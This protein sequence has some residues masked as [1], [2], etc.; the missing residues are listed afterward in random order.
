MS[1]CPTV[2]FGSQQKSEHPEAVQEA[3]EL[4]SEHGCVLLKSVLGQDYVAELHRAFVDTYRSYFEDREFPDALVVGTKRIQVTV[5]I[6]GPFN[7]PQLYANDCIL[8]V[9]K[10]V[11]GEQLIVGSFGAVVSLAGAPNQHRHRDHPN[12]YETGETE[13]TEPW[14]DIVLPPYALNAIVP[15]VP[16]NPTNGTTHLWPGSHLVP[17]SKGEQLP[18]VDPVVDIGDCLLVDYRTLHAGKA[19]LSAN[20]RPIL[21]NMY[22]RPWFRDSRNYRLQRPIQ[23]S[24]DEYFRIPEEFRALFHGWRR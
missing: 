11:L 23:I 7:S 17:K 10:L 19:N 3:A 15:L 24:R 5:A 21:Y 8:P 18:G 1:N 20:P 13:A 12:I 16:L 4:F 2:D 22:C 14:V 9:L 6:Q